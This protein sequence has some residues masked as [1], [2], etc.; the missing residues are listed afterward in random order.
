M[1][2]PVQVRPP[3]RMFNGTQASIGRP[4][5]TANIGGRFTR[6]GI[7]FRFEA[8][9]ITDEEILGFA[10]RYD[11]VKSGLCLTILWNRLNG[12]IDDNVPSAA[13]QNTALSRLTGL[14][15]SPQIQK[16]ILGGRFMLQF[17]NEFASSGAGSHPWSDW[18]TKETQWKLYIS[19]AIS[20][21]RSSVT[22]GDKI[23]FC[24]PAFT[25]SPLMQ[26]PDDQLSSQAQL[27]KAMM[28]SMFSFV[29]N[30]NLQYGFPILGMDVHLHKSSGAE[31]QTNIDAMLLE[32]QDSANAQYTNAQYRLHSFEWSPS[33][34][35]PR[36]DLTGAAQ[37]QTDI[38]NVMEDAGI[39]WA[40]Y[41]PLSVYGDSNFDWCALISSVTPSEVRNEPF[42][43]NYEDLAIMTA[44]PNN[45][46]VTCL[47]SMQSAIEAITDD[48]DGVTT[49]AF[50]EG[51]DVVPFEYLSR[52]VSRLPSN[53]A[54]G[55]YGCLIRYD[56]RMVADRSVP[57]ERAEQVRWTFAYGV[58]SQ[59][60]T[61]DYTG[62]WKT[63]LT[64]NIDLANRCENEIVS[65]A[66]TLYNANTITPL[67]DG[68]YLIFGEPLARP[69]GLQDQWLFRGRQ[70]TLGN[71]YT[72]SR[73]R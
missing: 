45:H 54:R 19:G 2:G 16:M 5:A 42:G 17:G 24:S 20:G 60:E 43:S 7:D 27:S 30:V 26:T 34:Y 10:N 58:I 47:E 11:N 32:A 31:A 18:P 59:G 39:W 66:A 68:P 46:E 23:Q 14:F 70:F 40:G 38:Y 53:G 22:N 9:S 37:V 25:S 62:T 52:W 41:G 65:T 50:P 6:G 57:V 61:D 67:T 64:N 71:I 36:S 21:L 72:S 63:S 73:K 44:T 35:Q 3:V 1:T 28:K 33:E 48:V 51:V 15:N 69:S 29:C 8:E 4:V 49:L 13:E 56:P 12:S 55:P